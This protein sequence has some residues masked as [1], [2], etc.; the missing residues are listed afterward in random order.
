MEEITNVETEV[1]NEE[2][3]NVESVGIKATPDE[4]IVEEEAKWYDSFDDE[5]KSK[6]E[7][8]DSMSDI[9]NKLEDANN[10]VNSSE[11]KYPEDL[12]DKDAVAKYFK[13]IG[14]PDQAEYKFDISDIDL[15]LIDVAK[16][17]EAF[18]ESGLNQQQAEAQMKSFIDLKRA[19]VNQK[20]QTNED[21]RIKTNIELTKEWGNDLEQN[22]NA[23]QDVA[24]ALGIADWLVENNLHEDKFIIKQLFEA[25]TRFDESSLN[26]T[27]PTVK[28]IQRQRDELYD[29]VAKTV[30]GTPE[31]AKL[32]AKYNDT[33][34]R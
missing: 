11:I 31:H 14:R 23:V 32:L 26:T 15:E 30:R 21:R 33:F 16:M 20:E 28:T 1:V 10:N 13:A 9:I 18:F 5:I 22:M 3:P 25:S 4:V 7:Q 6:V 12:N 17:K 19:E 27:K 34:R 2:T 8:Y 29:K 24:V